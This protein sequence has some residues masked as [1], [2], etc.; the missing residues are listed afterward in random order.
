[1]RSAV[2]WPCATTVSFNICRNSLV[3]SMHMNLSATFQCSAR[4]FETFWIFTR[5][6]GDQLTVCAAARSSQNVNSQTLWELK[7]LDHAP[8]AFLSNV[9]GEH[10]ATHSYY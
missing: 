2:A 5:M 7:W 8:Q 3:H 9:W 1:L 6:S 10:V 4:P